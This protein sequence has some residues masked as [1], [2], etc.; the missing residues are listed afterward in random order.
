VRDFPKSTPQINLEHIATRRALRFS[1]I[2]WGKRYRVLRG[3]VKENRKVPGTE[4]QAFYDPSKV[5]GTEG[6]AFYDPMNR[7]K[8]VLDAETSLTQWKIGAV[9]NSGASPHLGWHS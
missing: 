8:T 7:L 6:Q 3:Q 4:G 5:P 2:L 9:L 1:E